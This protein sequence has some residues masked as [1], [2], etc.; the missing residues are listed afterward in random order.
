[1]SHLGFSARPFEIPAAADYSFTF[2][3]RAVPAPPGLVLVL[4]GLSVLAAFGRMRV[5]RRTRA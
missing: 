1:M 3:V 2:D 4:L 5:R